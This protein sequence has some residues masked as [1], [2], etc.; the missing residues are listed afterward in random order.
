MRTLFYVFLFAVFCAASA[1]D[2]IVW[3]PRL[4][5]VTNGVIRIES[6]D[7]LLVP[8]ALQREVSTD[9]AEGTRFCVATTPPVVDLSF[10]GP[11][12]DAALNGTG[13]SSWGDICVADDG[14]VFNAIGD[15]GND[16]GGTARAFL[17]EWNPAARSLSLLVD[18]NRIVPRLRGEPAW[19]KV[20]GGIHQ[21]VD[22]FIYFTGTLNNGAQAASAGFKW[23]ENIPGGQLYRLNPETGVA[24][25]FANLPSARCTA[26]TGLDRKRSIWWCNLEGASNALF[27]LCLTNRAVVFRGKEG[28]VVFNRSFALAGDGT[29][30]F[31]GRNAIWKCRPGA[32][33]ARRTRAVLPAGD[34]MRAVTDQAKDGSFYGITMKGML[35][36]LRP[37]SD[38]LHMLGPC[39]RQG[40]YTAVCVLSPCERYLYYLPGSH[41]DAFR[42]GTPVVQY[43]ISTGRRKVLA[44]LAGPVAKACD[45]IPGG[46]YGVKT[47]ADG[48]TLYVNFNGHAADS[49]RPKPMQPTGF[50][51]TAFAAIHIPDSER[52]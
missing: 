11:L 27:G 12:P 26:T 15:H 3:P 13:W 46:T 30:Y 5:G 20:H 19:S 43:E 42:I 6:K 34:N 33:T 29:V 48:A 45:Y 47:S 4:R 37:G 32:R 40:V 2:S 17:F 14:R 25:V 10:H 16:A 24:E 41:G 49:A 31:N 39:F 7:F 22:G 35:F 50:G 28:D 51:L 44:F 23:S 38:K 18:V 1:D 9:D 21:G 36:C 52:P 8:G